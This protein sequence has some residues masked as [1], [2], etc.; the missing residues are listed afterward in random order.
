M[1]LLMKAAFS[2]RLCTSREFFQSSD[3]EDLT[4]ELYKE[5]L[6]YKKQENNYLT[7]PIDLASYRFANMQNAA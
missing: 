7:Q 3:M 5:V 1:K 2:N 6:K 4:Q